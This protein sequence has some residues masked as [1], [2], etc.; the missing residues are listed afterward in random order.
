MNQKITVGMRVAFDSEHGPQVGYVTGLLPCIGNGQI[1]ASIEIGREL[2]SIVFMMPLVEL[3]AAPGD[4]LTADDYKNLSHMLGAVEGRWPKSKWG[5]RNYYCA[6]TGAQ[7]SMQRLVDAGMV[8]R[9]GQSIGNDGSVYFHATQHGCKMM[10]LD[11]AGIKR[12]M[13]SLS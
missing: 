6:G 4:A 2:D 7:A 1:H 9:G 13:E 11:H 5:W 8:R 10:G 12:A 3:T